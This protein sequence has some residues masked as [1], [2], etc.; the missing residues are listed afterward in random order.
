MI[1]YCGCL[2]C[3]Q[4]IDVVHD[5]LL[6]INNK[7]ISCFPCKDR[8]VCGAIYYAYEIK[9]NHKVVPIVDEGTGFQVCHVKGAIKLR[10]GKGILVPM[11]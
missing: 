2:G 5:L 3:G 9:E 8:N 4:E 10:N 1:Y 11:E 7:M 6:K